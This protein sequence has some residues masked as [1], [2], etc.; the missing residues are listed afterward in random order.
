MEED[1]DVID[2]DPPAAIVHKK[3]FYDLI[4]AQEKV[5]WLSKQ[6][7]VLIVSSR[8]DRY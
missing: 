6:Q 3:V 7:F 5:G 4:A 8:Q 2:Y 1:A